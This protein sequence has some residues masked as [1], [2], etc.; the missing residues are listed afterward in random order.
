VCL[1]EGPL[2]TT[3]TQIQKKPNLATIPTARRHDIGHRPLGIYTSVPRGM[4]TDIQVTPKV[5]ARYM[6]ERGRDFRTE[7]NHSSP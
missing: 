6:L 1:T 5:P 2:Q 3:Y 4:R 7:G